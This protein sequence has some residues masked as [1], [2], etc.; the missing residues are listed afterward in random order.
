MSTEISLTLHCL[1]P[2]YI[3]S[4]IQIITEPRSWKLFKSFATNIVKRRYN[5]RL[6]PGNW[7][8]QSRPQSIT[9]T[10]TTLEGLFSIRCRYIFNRLSKV[11]VI[12]ISVVCPCRRCRKSLNSKELKVKPSNRIELSL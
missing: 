12:L 1:V 8:Q 10:D 11:N 5:E 3:T 7:N 6:T 4:P 2:N 9:P